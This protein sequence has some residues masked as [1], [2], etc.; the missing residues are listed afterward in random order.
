MRLG[1]LAIQGAFEK[2]SQIL[3]KIGTPEPI[4]VRQPQ[5]LEGLDALFLPGGETSTMSK[6]LRFNGLDAP[7]KDQ[8]ENGIPIFATCAGLI[9]LASEVK[10]GI[11]DQYNFS[12]LDISITR[13]AY[14]PQIESFQADINISELNISELGISKSK[15]SNTS[16]AYLGVFIR[17]PIIN[18]V[19]EK[20]KVLAHHENNPVLCQQDN[21]LAATFHP[22][23]TKDTRIHEFFLNNFVDNKE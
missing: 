16:S 6:L 11:E 8:L 5:E 20:V 14:G 3:K 22:E 17:S 9:L 21:I 19:G 2:H 23:L 12:A 13:N 10:G 7:L 18:R 15:T 4:F 1:I